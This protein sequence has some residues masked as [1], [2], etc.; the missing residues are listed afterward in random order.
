[1]A[2]LCGLGGAGKTSMAIEYA[3]RHLAEVA[4]CW[5][6]PAEDPAVLTAE[7]G[8]L[9][10]QLG[11]REVVDPR[12]PVASVHGVLAQIQAGWLLVFDNAPDRVSI[13][14]FVPPAGSG[15]VLITTQNQHWPPGQTLNVPVLDLE[16]AA[17]FL[18]N[19][20]DDPDLPT[21]RE[22]A[23]QLGGLPLALEQAA[24]YMQATGDSF[25]DYLASFRRRRADIL[26][27]GEPADYGKT[28]ATTFALA[29]DRLRQASPSAVGLLRLLAFFAP[30]AIPL[31]RLSQP[32]PELLQLLSPGVKALLLPLLMDPLA[33]K[34]AIAALRAHSLI[35]R[36]EGG[37]A[38]MHRLSAY[39]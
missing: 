32:R 9:A 23:E 4:V 16:A 10:A 11:A 18:V 30:E 36:P 22:L 12:D 39:P 8:A 6:F 14:R 27:R 1:V 35:S 7:F 31:Q 21:A 24:A 26:A 17:G 37:S 38:S 28:V 3:H 5:Q 25:T 2:V 34:D 13:L 19:R 29:F 33:A 15:R 20:T